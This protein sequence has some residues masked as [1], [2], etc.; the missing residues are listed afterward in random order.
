MNTINNALAEYTD[1]QQDRKEQ[2][3]P[4]D[5]RGY[6]AAMIEKVWEMDMQHIKP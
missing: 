5:R 4:G 6:I 1:E 2:C 3:G